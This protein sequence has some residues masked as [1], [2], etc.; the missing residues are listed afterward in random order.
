[1]T[2]AAHVRFTASPDEVRQ[3]LARPVRV[4]AFTVGNSIAIQPMEGCDGTLDGNPGELTWRR[5]ERFARGGAKLIWFEATAVRED[6]RA[7]TRQLW[8][9]PR[10]VADFARLLA[11]VREVH[12][13]HWGSADD[14]LVPIQLTHSGR[15]SVPRR[16]IAYH[17][18]HI[19]RKTG[20]PPD[21]PAIADDELER[22]EDDY[23][24]AAG[25][26][27]EA[28]FQAVDIKAVHGY[29]ISELLGAKT[30]DGRYGGP[31]ENRLRF[32]RNMIGKLRAAF[33]NRL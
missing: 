24:S 7:N 20:T 26:A 29:L 8:I 22:L 28:G 17:N 32:I 15:Y 16:I 18:P 27:L 12:R 3:V 14:L 6:G 2:G 11:R 19:D 31:L 1:M 13:E 30:R 23:V 9:T 4:G 21:Y 5:Y 33:G 25:L 10:N